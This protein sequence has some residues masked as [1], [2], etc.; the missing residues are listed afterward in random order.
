[1]AVGCLVTDRNERSGYSRTITI[2]RPMAFKLSRN[3]GMLVLFGAQKAEK[4]SG[5]LGFL[6]PELSNGIETQSLVNSY[7]PLRINVRYML[8]GKTV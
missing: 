3:L 4:I 5:G 7:Q 2:N 6:Q 1:M 8:E